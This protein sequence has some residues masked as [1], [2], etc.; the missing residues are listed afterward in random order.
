MRLSAR[1]T[2]ASCLRAIVFLGHQRPIPSQDGVRCDD[3]RDGRQSAPAKNLAFHG[4][5]AALVVGDM[6]PSRSVR[7]AEDSVLLEQVVN[8]CLL[9]SVDPAGDEENNEHERRRQR[10]HGASVPERLAQCKARRDS[11]SA[12]PGWAEFPD[13]KP[14]ATRGNAPI[15]EQSGLGGVFAQDEVSRT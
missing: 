11:R 2:T 3:T 14:P 9:L 8:N 10:V 6:E 1:A 12:L 4:Q 7:G 5:A 13:R 15:V